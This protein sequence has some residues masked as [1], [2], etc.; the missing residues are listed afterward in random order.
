MNLNHRRQLIIAATLGPALGPVLM[1]AIALAQPT[2]RPRR[3]GYLSLSKAGSPTAQTSWAMI[4]D[5]LRRAGWQA[6]ANLLI[7][8]RNAEGEVSRLDA[9]AAELV[10]LNVELIIAS[11]N[12]PIAAA[13]RATGTVPIVMLGANLPV[14]L[15]FV[16]SLARPGGNVTGTAAPDPQTAMKAIEV[17]KEIAPGRRRLALLFNPSTPGVQALNAARGR[18]AQMLGMTVQTFAVTRAD[19]ITAALEQIAASRAEMLFVAYDGVTESRLSDITAFAIQHKMLAIGPQTL[20]T[21]AGGAIYYGSNLAEIVD[22]TMS[23]VDRILRGAKPA[24]L[25]VEQPTRFDLIIN[26]KTMRALGIT[27]PAAV[28][29][30]ANEVIE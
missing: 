7:E 29:A 27:V 9:L 5:S 25:P 14:E 17:L 16:Q 22:R 12:A 3:I 13:K 19:E 23:Y 4:L 18:A 20:F 30:R 28:L 21:S 24:E 2:A 10:G 11:L 26:L 8:R 15:G 1:P 6:G